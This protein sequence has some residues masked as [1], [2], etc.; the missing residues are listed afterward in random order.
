MQLEYPCTYNLNY[1]IVTPIYP[2]ITNMFY[3]SLYKSQ[4]NSTVIAITSIIN[5]S[6]EH[7]LPMFILFLPFC[8]MVL[9]IVRVTAII[10]Y[11]LFFLTFI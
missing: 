8:M 6:N 4:K 9:Y 11:V 2:I 7:F 1:L 5:K 3:T 10:Y